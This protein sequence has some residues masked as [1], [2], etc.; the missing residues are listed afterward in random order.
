M[1]VFY[2]FD[3]Y[4]QYFDTKLSDLIDNFQICFIL[5]KRQ[6][7]QVMNLNEIILY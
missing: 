1:Y 7:A 3:F 4:L 2:L 5:N 6:I